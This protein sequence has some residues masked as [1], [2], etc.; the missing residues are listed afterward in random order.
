MIA[1]KIRRI[2]RRF[3]DAQATSPRNAKTLDELGLWHSLV[4]TRLVNQSVFIESNPGRYFLHRV[5]L[6]IYNQRRRTRM[7]AV[8]VMIGVILIVALFFNYFQNS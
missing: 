8:L 1:I 3:E 7:M 2:I 5:N 4:F 6:A